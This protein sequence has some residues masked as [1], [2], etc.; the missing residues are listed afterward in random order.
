[1]VTGL[2]PEFEYFEPSTLQEACAILKDREGA[3]I[4]AGGTDLIISMRDRK[5]APRHVVN[6]KR[7]PKLD[8]I[9]TD[10]GGLRMGALTTIGAIDNSALVRNAFPMVA[11]AAHALGCLQVRNRATLGGNLC[12]SSPS[13]DMAPPLIV[14]GTMAKIVGSKGERK[15]PLEDFFTGPGKTVLARDEILTELWVPNLAIN[16]HGAFVK[17]G[18]RTAMDIAVVNAAGVF[19]MNGKVCTDARMVLGAVA[20][21]PLRIKK[22]EAAIRRREVDEKNVCKVAEVAAEECRPISDVRGSEDYRR[23]IVNVLIR[24]LF[25]EALHLQLPKLRGAR[26]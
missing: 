4:L 26:P 6:I 20:P 5:I 22:S 7:I 25:A 8:G 2:P 17:Q 11:E 9:F 19:V 21:T 24:R 14:L 18:P 15:V 10:E 1:M 23:Q 3:K 16:S 13:A 12:N